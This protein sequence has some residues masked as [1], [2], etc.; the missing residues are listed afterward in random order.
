MM[1]HSRGSCGVFLIPADATAACVAEVTAA[2]ATAAATAEAHFVMQYYGVAA[3]ACTPNL[4][5]AAI[6]SSS[7]YSAPLL[8]LSRYTTR[9]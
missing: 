2:D 7:F 6:L 1:G 3:V 8:R 9:S 5:Y 4:L